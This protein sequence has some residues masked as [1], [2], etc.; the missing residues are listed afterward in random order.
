MSTIKPLVFVAFFLFTTC[1]ID[2][3]KEESV[4]ETI[5]TSINIALPISNV[6]A[7]NLEINTISLDYTCC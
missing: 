1:K 4:P 3:E 7:D 2:T 6:E 5:P